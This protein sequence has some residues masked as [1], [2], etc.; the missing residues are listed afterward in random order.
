MS[1]QWVQ[2]ASI[3]VV[4]LFLAPLP[5][6]APAEQERYVIA[7]IAGFG[8]APVLAAH[9]EVV[10][11]Y[12]GT[13][14]LLRVT[15]PEA[16]QLRAWGIPIT[17]LAD[18]T[19]IRFEDAGIRFDTSLGEPDLAPTLRASDPHAFIVQ[20]IG[21]I[22]PEWMDRI[23]TLGGSPQLYV[24]NA[25]F[26]VRMSGGTSRAV[27]ALP[28]VNW[29]GAYHPAYKI[30][31]SLSN[32]Q[33][34]TRI[35]IL[36][37]DDISELTLA[38]K[39]FD[40]GADVFA[41][42]HSPPLVQGFVEGYRIP[43]IAA[44]EEVAIVF[45][46][47]LPQP[48]DLKAGVVHGFNLAWYKET[49]GLP[50]TLT[51]VSNGP[52]GIRGNA[53]DIYEI[54]GIQDTGLDEGSASAGANDFFR[55]PTSLGSQNDRVISFTDRTS[56]SV[57]DG[58]AGGRVA[59]GTHVAGIVASNG[60][61]WE[62]YLIEDR[63][64]TS[65][66][67]D[68]FRWDRSEAGVAP[69]AK[70]VVD[71][72]NGCGGGVI[73]NSLYWI[74]EYNAGA[75]VMVNSWGSNSG[76]QYDG[77][78]QAADDQMDDSDGDGSNDRLIEFSAGNDG[79]QYNTLGQQA[80]LKNGLSIGASENF[81]PDQFEADNPDLM[82]SFSS[83]G[84]PNQGQ[85]RIKPDLVSI[86]TAVVSLFSRGEWESVGSTPQPDYILSVDKYNANTLSPGTDGIPDYR[87]LQ[88][89]SMAG[90]M[91][92]GLYLLAREYL[93][94]VRGIP[95]PNSQLIKALLIN[96][97]VR[98]DSD[99]YAYPGWDQGWGR[100]DLPNSLFPNPPKTVQFE[101]GTISTPGATWNP[102]SVNLTVASGNVP[103]KVTLVWIDQPGNALA[104]DLNLRV[105][106][107]GGGPV[108]CGNNYVAGW[109][110]AFAGPNCG[111]GNTT[112]DADGNGWDQV[113][114]VEQVE[115]QNPAAGLWSVQVNGFA[116]PSAA[117]FAVV[118]SSNIGP[119]SQY[120]VALS[121]SAPTTFSIAPSGSANL[122]FR[123]TNFGTA[124]D[125]VLL[126]SPGA[127]GGITVRFSPTGPLNIVRSGSEDV[128]ASIQVALGIA[129]GLYH[130]NLQGTSDLDPNP[131]GASSD[132]IPVTV[133][134]TT[135]QVAFPTIVANGTTDEL[136]PSV[137][138]FNTTAGVR[139]AFVAYRKT[140][141]VL[142]GG[143]LGGVNV[144]VAHTTL[145]GSGMPALPFQQFSVSSANDQP[146]DL[147]LLRIPSGTFADRVVLTWTGTDPNVT[148]PDA[149][150]YG[151]VAFADAPYATWN[152]RTMETNFGS[153]NFNVARVSFPLFRR[154]GGGAG[155]LMWVFEHLD[156]TTLTGNPVRVQ[157]HVTISTNGGN[158]WAVPTRV[159][160]VGGTDTNFYFFPHG[161]VD[162]NDVA[163]IY[164]YFRTPTGND[165]DLA[166]RLYDGAW[167]TTAPV[168]WDTTDNIQWPA[169]L[170]TAEG[171]FGNRIYTAVTRDALAVDLK[172]WIIYIDGGATPWSSV[173]V[174]RNGL[175]P[176]FGQGIPCGTGCTISPDY[177]GPFGPFSSSASNA[178]YNRRPILN[179]VRTVEGPTTYIWLPFM[180]N[181]NPYGT[182]NLHTLYGTA[183]NWA[184]ATPSLTKITSDGYAKGHQMT[185][186]LT[187]GG[188]ARLYEVYHASRTPET[189]V[190]YQI[191]LAIYGR[192]WEASADLTGPL[193]VNP[194]SVPALV[195]LAVTNAMR[196]S[197]NVN[198][199][200]T[201]NSTIA[202]AEFFFDALGAPGSGRALAPSDG[203]FDSPTEAVQSLA[204]VEPTWSSPSCHP[205][206][207]RGQDAAGNWGAASA[208][209]VCIQGTAG[210]DTTP[211]IAPVIAGARL[212]GAGFSDVQIT[213]RASTD[214]GFLGGTVVYQV[215]RAPNLA[216]PFA[217]IGADI[218]GAGL[219]TYTYTDVGVAPNT[220]F[221][222]VR[223]IDGV[224]LMANST[225]RAGRSQWAVLAGTN[226][227]STP[228]IQSD[229]SIGTVFQTVNLRG[230]WTYDGCTRT[231]SSWSSSRLAGQNTLQTVSHRVGVIVDLVS[232][233]TF[234][235]A[236]IV[237][238]TTPIS[239]CTGWNLVG[240]PSFRPS[241]T[242]ANLK[243]E[244]GATQV[245][246]FAP[247]APGNT[248]VLSDP[249]VLQ[250][251][252]AYWV[253]VSAPSVW[254]VPGQ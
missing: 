189:A 130:F 24:A 109:S 244:T 72:V 129:P 224:G 106:S 245:L 82:A 165:R 100:I 174:P 252:L 238:T 233:G 153:S 114:N 246:G 6:M 105:T 103:L 111:A 184:T 216:G 220:Y 147:R 19:T 196:I 23:R 242:V 112:W 169:V 96:G 97:A 35:S 142:L 231:W 89:T 70:L 7:E 95:N 9:A 38:K 191:Y 101:E 42:A 192:N 163:W 241:Y 172:L 222:Y 77:F 159:F 73:T 67:T 25:A 223:S 122:P 155:E 33:G 154:A 58:S 107:P 181:N 236:G 10:E 78:A 219:L 98:M 21:P 4:V 140:G 176:P 41:V 212:S 53:D 15:G 211:P 119:T 124:A 120:R 8:L 240:N 17:E 93:R 52:D 45:N 62:K 85:G 1:A 133:E 75:R 91:A 183:A 225:Q 76:G 160:P 206:Y 39:V 138:V 60:Y 162:Q 249:T 253:R 37:F 177:V 34:R 243:A 29:V 197:A 65:V 234:A 188:V 194:T 186:T 146:N 215:F 115:I 16:A 64:D 201:G 150:S 5:A 104:R 208:T 128:L 250:P 198:D 118:V 137:L 26:V 152:L 83:R 254:I 51:G 68:D 87:Y 178:N 47:P 131:A 32:E 79:P 210:P 207:I 185:D 84:G 49:S 50:S 139:H 127:P 66:S 108:Y 144:W 48:L 213:W 116:V 54:A 2:L 180:E 167:S 166:V 81:R 40:L 141:P 3:A 179:L 203:A 134:V 94:E 74:D 168:V 202:A 135:T 200:S 43:A 148:N 13:M 214:E 158:S 218:T 86:G 22:K 123:V 88:G 14:A 59:H 20:F 145:D 44:L 171:A 187:T 228:F 11:V 235:V 31:A 204:G 247:A 143:R 209:Q 132:S 161:A 221:Y 136:D 229:E 113:N 217:Q 156:Y 30:P 205:I 149:A 232:A 92:A 175:P 157:T 69:E 18:R 190:D 251:G 230:A 102:A 36:G 99:L 110:R 248:V 182:P 193:T 90:P 173:L 28:F 195:D 126:A 237:P 164:A 57:P 151:R 12:E 80:N 71:G 56:C 61:S 227:V 27:A 125:R 63:G 46:D 226:Y 170:S 239:L 117:K 199:M 55:G 121:T